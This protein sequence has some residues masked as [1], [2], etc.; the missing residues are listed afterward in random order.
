[1]P[2]NG[3]ATE[4]SFRGDCVDPRTEEDPA[5]R[6]HAGGLACLAIQS[7]IAQLSAL[8]PP[9][10]SYVGD[11]GLPGDPARRDDFKISGGLKNGNKA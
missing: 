4:D 7:A 3:F 9:I 10:N 6:T 1:M 8:P 2:L 5:C 11:P